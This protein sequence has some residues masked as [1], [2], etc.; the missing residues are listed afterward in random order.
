[1]KSKRKFAIDCDGVLFD[2]N[3]A[4]GE[5]LEH[6]SGISIPPA[7]RDWPTQWD[8]E[9]P[10]GITKKQKREAWNYIC[11]DGSY[12]FWRSLPA[13]EWSHNFLAA[14]PHEGD[15][16][17]VT[18][19]CGTMCQKATADALTELGVVDP[20]V[21]IAHKKAPVL[22]A[23]GV[24]DFL[25]DR[26]KNFKDLITYEQQFKSIPIRKWLLDQPWNRAYAGYMVHRID[27]PHTMFEGGF[28]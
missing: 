9:L 1:M 4:Y 12:R 5:L 2:F 20:Q 23:E 22:L 24:T 3:T 7:T 10:L 11:G 15:F 6:I 17:F 14:L 28:H 18:A 13:Y 8:W 26:D 25:D 19:R 27:S 21:F 16:I